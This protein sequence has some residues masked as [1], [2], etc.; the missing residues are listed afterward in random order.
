MGILSAL[1]LESA[2]DGGAADSIKSGLAEWRKVQV[3]TPEDLFYEIERYT[4]DAGIENPQTLYTGDL[5]QADSGMG[6]IE[7]SQDVLD[8]QRAAMTGLTD[9]A[10]EGITATEQADIRSLMNQEAQKQKGAR[11]AIMQNY[12]ERGIAGSGG[13]LAS[14]LLNQQASA[15]RGAQG[16]FDIAALGK[17]RALEALTS[18][19][20]LAGR[21]RGQEF[22]EQAQQ[23][24][25]Q[26]AINAFNINQE[27]QT[28]AGNADILNAAATQRQQIAM[29]QADQ[30][31]AQ[32]KQL[33]DNLKYQAAA[34]GD[35]AAGISG[36][37]NTLAAQQQAA[38]A[39]QNSALRNTLGAAATVVGSI[40][41]GP[42]GGAA[43]GAAA[44]AALAD[45]GV[46]KGY[47][48]SAN[49]T[50]VNTGGSLYA[51]ACGGKMKGHREDGG[52]VDEGG[53]YLVGEEG[54]ELVTPAQ[55]G[56]VHPA[57]QT[58]AILS[59]ITGIKSQRDGMGGGEA[60]NA[61]VV[62]DIQERLRNLE[63]NRG[64]K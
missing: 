10:Q 55:D 31:T 23:A 22:G 64:N 45:G 33:G 25:A 21:V 30:Q 11:E 35:K 34:M 12:A 43:A 38:A 7:V 39:S 49:S 60:M 5:R 42:A 13:E 15:D 8:T 37:Y 24:S 6:D 54:A 44:D 61:C 36:Q 1:G 57:D 20:D 19:G 4:M 51:R 27:M 50:V 58:E 14:Q 18:S 46:M 17:M 26:D 48:D 62:N 32:R 16:A 47:D 29:S 63:A 28:R 3:P 2:D 56:M 41:G 9:V 59:A 52:G 53:T 40:Y